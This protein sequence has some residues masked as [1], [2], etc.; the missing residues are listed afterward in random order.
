MWIDNDIVRSDLEN[1]INSP[2]IDWSIFKGKN[3]F[4]TG[5]TGLIGSTIV[6]V[7]VYANIKL[8]LGIDITALV[9]NEDKAKVLF[10]K[11]I[12]HG[13]LHFITGTVEN[14]K[15]SDQ[16]YDYIIHAASPTSSKLFQNSPV[17]IIK[18]SI[19][20]TLNIL[21]LARQI[22]VSGMVFL[23]TME[24][25]GSPETDEK[26]NEY[27][28]SNLDTTI[29]RSSY[30]ES[31]R[32]CEVLCASYASEYGVPVKTIR[33]TQTFGPGVQYDDSRVFAEFARCVIKSENIVLA[34][35]GETKRN[36]LYTIDA[37]TAIL[38]L[39]QKGKNGEAYNAANESSYCSI[40]ELANHFVDKFGN[41]IR[42]VVDESKAIGRGF[43]PVLHMNLDTQKIAKL[44]WRP[45]YSLNQ[46][47]FN[48]IHTMKS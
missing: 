36:Y 11:Q 48:L 39:L 43:A 17:E 47:L 42:V 18:T 6:N 34:T 46:M 37:V 12:S 9:R 40:L 38:L 32:L 44:G 31:K 15:I 2:F 19:Y 1:A 10:D 13:C 23:S 25:Y 28:S 14:F 26:I 21:E 27:H 29:P 35:K 24:V 7:L 3:F 30:P 45:A 8:F 41:N 5:A 33:L 16:H 20:G 22:H 4:I